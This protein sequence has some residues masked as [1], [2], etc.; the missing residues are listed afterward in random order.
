MYSNRRYF[1]VVNCDIQC[2]LY[3]SLVCSFISS[4]KVANN[5]V[6]EI[7]KGE[8]CRAVALGMTDYAINLRFQKHTTM[9]GMTDCEIDE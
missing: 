8:A 9:C 4:R 5:M 6:S 1:I 2:F 7:P 3:D